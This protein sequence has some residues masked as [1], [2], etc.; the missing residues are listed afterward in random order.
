[1]RGSLGTLR[2]MFYK[3]PRPTEIE[4]SVNAALPPHAIDVF[5]LFGLSGSEKVWS[6]T[7]ALALRMLA[8]HLLTDVTTHTW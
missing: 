4:L 6:K 3:K 2:T 7:A 1:M 8:E 5:V